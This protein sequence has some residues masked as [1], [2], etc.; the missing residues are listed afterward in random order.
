MENQN[1]TAEF[2]DKLIDAFCEQLKQKMALSRAKGR[3][4]WN[5]KSLTPNGV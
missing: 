2:E 5:D 4:G 1:K 3:S